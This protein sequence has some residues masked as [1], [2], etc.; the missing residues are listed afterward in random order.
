MIMNVTTTM[1]GVIEIVRETEQEIQTTA[2]GVVTHIVLATD[3]HEPALQKLTR[4]K[5]I[6]KRQLLTVS[7]N[8]AN[9]V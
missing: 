8:I 5:R 7:G 2:M 4:T 1:G 9:L 3:V 6:A